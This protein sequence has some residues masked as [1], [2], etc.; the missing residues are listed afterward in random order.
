MKKVYIN[1]KETDSGKYGKAVEMQLKAALDL[2]ICVSRQG[3]TDLRKACTN[4]EVKTGAGELGDLG[5]RLVK[6]CSAVLYVPVPVVS[7]D[8]NGEYIDLASCDGYVLTRND[9]LDALEE[10]G[11]IRTKRSTS[12]AMKVT[13]QTFWNRSKNAPHGALL[14]KRLIPAL[15]TYCSATLAEWLEQYEK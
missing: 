1:C 3:R 9:F 11:A 5:K 7:C 2:K 12:G 14:E 6:G 13:I 15:E 10:A 4:Y 8:D